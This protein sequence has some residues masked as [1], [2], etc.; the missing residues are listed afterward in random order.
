MLHQDANAVAD[1]VRKVLQDGKVAVVIMH[2]YG[3]I[4]GPEGVATVMEEKGAESSANFGS[5]RRL[6]FLAAHVLEKG[7]SMEG[8]RGKMPNMDISEV[9]RSPLRLSCPC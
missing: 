6:V 1:T 5:V 2:S 7:I 4:S 9:S 8:L 3:G